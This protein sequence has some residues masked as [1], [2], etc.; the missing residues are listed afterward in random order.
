MF[1]SND[2][3]VLRNGI[4]YA[5]ELPGILSEY[6]RGPFKIDNRFSLMEHPHSQMSGEVELYSEVGERV[7]SAK[8]SEFNQ[9][10]QNFNVH[11][12]GPPPPSTT[13]LKKS[14]PKGSTAS[15]TSSTPQ[16]PIPVTSQKL[17]LLKLNL[18]PRKYHQKPRKFR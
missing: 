12:T 2:E 8:V 1:T 7:R 16:K 3:N 18:P 15:L 4:G 13:T 9:F 17:L 6:S 5:E 10:V 11:Y 14:T